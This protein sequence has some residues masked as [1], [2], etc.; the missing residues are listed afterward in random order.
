MSEL[1]VITPP[2]GEALSL[3]AAKEML[4]L[5]TDGEDALVARLIASA[6]AQIEVASGLALVSRTLKRTWTRWPVAVAHGG[7]ALRPGPVTALVSVTR[8]DGAGTEEDLSARFEVCGGKLRLKA[9][10]AMPGI[11]AGGRVEVVFVAGFG[12]AEAVP[13]DLV[14]ALK[15]WVQAAYLRGAENPPVGI[16][17][18]V[19]RIL[20]AHREWAI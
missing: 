5:G 11:A 8:I 10:W 13:E 16:P 7:A 18:D 4:R 1:T 20:D 9:G 15:L 14:H 2:A 19:Q 6:R 17:E 12:A 3:Q